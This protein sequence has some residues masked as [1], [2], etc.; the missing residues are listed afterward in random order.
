VGVGG[1]FTYLYNK[2]FFNVDEKSIR[3]EERAKTLKEFDIDDLS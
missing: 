2:F 3:Q 1:A